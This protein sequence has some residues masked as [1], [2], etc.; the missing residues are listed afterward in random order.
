MKI[1]DNYC[2]YSEIHESSSRDFVFS[3]YGRV[4]PNN[5]STIKAS[6]IE[7]YRI[8]YC[9]LKCMLS[10]VPKKVEK[11]EGIKM[12][13][14]VFPW[15]SGISGRLRYDADFRC[16]RCL[17]GDSAQVVLLSEVELEPGVKVESVSPKFCYL[18]DTLGSGG[19]VV[20]A[21]IELE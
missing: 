19:G 4:G 17:D 6:Q 8:S 1:T 13:S 21:A 10:R 9:F 16:M 2:F 7:V 20:E 11:N 18:G 14:S 5:G 15:C 3:P 12:P